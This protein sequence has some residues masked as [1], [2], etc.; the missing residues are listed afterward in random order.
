MK[1]QITHQYDDIIR[2]QRPDCGRRARMSLYD[3]AAQFSPFAALTGFDDAIAETG[4]QT[5]DRIELD[6]DA[7]DR[8][9]E[10]MQGLLEVLDSQ[11]EAEVVWFRYDERKAGGSYVTTT[12]HVKKVDTYLER[13]IFTDGRS[14]PLG[15]VLSVTV[16]K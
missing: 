15:E 4:R 13:M 5:Q 1:L 3:R 11:P 8:L 10:Q 7:L 9:D 6:R 2:L 14:I 16:M 12:G